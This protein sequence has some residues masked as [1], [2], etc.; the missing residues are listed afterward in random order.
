MDERFEAALEEAKKIDKDIEND[1]ISAKDFAQKPFLGV[2]F[3]SKEST[4]CKGLSNSFALVCRKGAIAKEDANV[5]ALMKNAGGILLAV[6]NIP[7]LNL[8]QETSNPVFGI[9]NN[10]YNTTRNVGGSSGGEASII[11]A[12]GSPFGIG[13]DIGGSIR[14][15]CYMC[16]IFGHKIS[17]GLTSTKG[18]L[19]VEKV[20][21]L[22]VL[23]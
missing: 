10:P 16:G 19:F 8:W 4:A 17:N 22:C 21:V 18:N 14:I 5:V 12:C 13:T 3:T 1:V 9:T 7:Q 11:A 15:P 23:T 2:P 6:T 20:K